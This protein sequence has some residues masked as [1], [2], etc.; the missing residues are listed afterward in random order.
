[1]LVQYGTYIAFSWDIME[2]ITC[3]MTL[4]D[5]VCSY[6]FWVWSKRPYSIQGL[7]DFFFERSKQKH[8]RKNKLDF[9]GLKQTD[10][11]IKILRGR[12]DELK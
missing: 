10:A 12:L 6:L 9:E 1:M 7:S 4:G 3:G 5:A 11:A 2:P 8:I